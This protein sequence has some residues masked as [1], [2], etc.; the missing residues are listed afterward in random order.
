MITADKNFVIR[1]SGPYY[2][3]STKMYVTYSH[4]PQDDRVRAFVTPYIDDIAAPGEIFEFSEADLTAETS[5]GANAVEESFGLLQEAVVTA[6]EALS[7][8][9]GAS[10]SFN[11]S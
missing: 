3:D 9:T 6:L 7:Y 4:D 1:E 2:P 10:V 5:F 11:I 8:N